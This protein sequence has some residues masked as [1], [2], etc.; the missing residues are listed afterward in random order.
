MLFRK[1]CLGIDIGTTTI[2]VVLLSFGNNQPKLESYGILENYAHL[3]RV[4]EAIQTSNFKLVEKTTAKYLGDLL[5]KSNIKIREAIFSIPCFNTYTNILELPPLSQKDLERAVYFQ[6]KQYVPMALSEVSIDWQIVYQDN[7]KTK[8]L[9]V[10]VPKEFISRYLAIAKMTNIR[11]IKMEL[12]SLASARSLIGN[13][14]GVVSIV[15]VGGRSSTISI[16]DNGVLQS[17][18][19]MDIAGGDLTQVIST[20]LNIIPVRAEEI[21]RLYGLKPPLGQEEVMK[22]M[23][24]LLGVIEQEMQREFSFFSKKTN[25]N[26]EKIYLTGGIANLPGITEYISNDFKVP[27]F[28]GNPFELGLIKFDKKLEPVVKEIGSSLSVACGLLMK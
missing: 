28:E 19:T 22:L 8:V 9:L 7:T 4:N 25:K 6:A 2:K 23:L 18:K 21:K 1:R 20:G 10:A 13:E 14:R 17:M 5:K 3:E 15:D 12:E 27:V 26:I 16:F 24:P 11:I